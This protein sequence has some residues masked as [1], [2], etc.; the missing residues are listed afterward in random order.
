MSGEK[1]SISKFENSLRE[2]MISLQSTQFTDVMSYTYKYNNLKFYMVPS[3]VKDPHF[4][5]SLGISEACYSITNGNK[6][7][8]SLGAEDRL[9]YKW[10]GRTNIHRELETYWK[11]LIEQQNNKRNI[12]SHSQT[13]SSVDDG[14]SS[15]D[16]TATGISKMKRIIVQEKKRRL[17]KFKKQKNR[18]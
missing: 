9:V 6:I 4:Y 3:K 1:E 11:E 10:A 16:M 8:G 15:I 18:G 12:S 17:L 2:Y 14:L 7:E 5:V 13:R